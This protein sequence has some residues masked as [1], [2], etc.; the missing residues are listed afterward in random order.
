MGREPRFPRSGLD[1]VSALLNRLQANGH[2]VRFSRK[3][4]QRGKAASQEVTIFPLRRALIRYLSGGQGA[5]PKSQ[6]NAGT[7]LKTSG[8]SAAAK[9]NQIRA[10][11]MAILAS[12]QELGTLSEAPSFVR[13]FHDELPEHPVLRQL[14]L[15]PPF[16]PKAF[17]RLNQTP[18]DWEKEAGRD[19][20][21]CLADRRRRFEFWVEQAVD[22]AIP[23][24]KGT[25]A[26]G[27]GGRRNTPME[28]R[29]RWASQYLCGVPLKEIAA[30]S[31]ADTTTVG[32]IA[33][34]L[35]RRAEWR[36]GCS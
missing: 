13:Q 8:Q 9:E 22:E 32:R 23:A 30:Q 7:P 25:R 29:F 3:S 17:D 19:F 2:Y 27:A 31:D 36:S 35:L 5:N 10:L 21:K 12:L 33:R 18:R 16:Q 34:T 4:A 24:P 15:P 28:N 1:A 26:P 20:Q 14:L 6:R 11:R